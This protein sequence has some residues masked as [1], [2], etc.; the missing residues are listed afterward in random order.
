V[1]GGPKA[2]SGTYYYVLDLKGIDGVRYSDQG[3]VTL[4]R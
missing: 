2:A 1:N 3:T 4:L